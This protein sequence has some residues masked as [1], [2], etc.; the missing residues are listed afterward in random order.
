MVLLKQKKL[1]KNIAE[2]ERKRVSQQKSIRQLIKDS[3]YSQEAADHPKKVINTKSWQELVKDLLPDDLILSK[4]KRNAL[5]NKSYL[6]S[7]Q[8]ID[9]TMKIKGGYAAQKIS[10]TTPQ[11]EMTDEQL[12]AKEAELE[13]K[14]KERKKK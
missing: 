4:L 8:A 6:A 1:L 11:D 10:L 5:Q 12:K 2:N 14:L 9:I 3:G 13:A 7:N